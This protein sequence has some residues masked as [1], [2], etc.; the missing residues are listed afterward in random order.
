MASKDPF[1]VAVKPTG[2]RPPARGWAI[3][4]YT[5]AGA[6]LAAALL[7][8]AFAPLES[9]AIAGGLV[10]VDS[11]RKQVQHLEGGIVQKIFVR[12]GEQVQERQELIRLEATKAESTVTTLKARIVAGE[13]QLRLVQDELDTVEA[14]LKRGQATRPR[15]L[16]LQ[17]RKAELQGQIAEHRSELRA[18]EDQIERAVI[19][20]PIAGTVIELK[21]HTA[22]GVIKAG[23]PL[24]S[25]VPRD[26]P[27]VIEAHIDPND[28][29][30]VRPGLAAHIRLTPYNMRYA[31]PL[32]GRVSQV[33][34]DR[35][36][37]PKSG[38]A[39]Y[40]A[41]VQLT[42]KPSEIDPAMKLYPGMPAEVII[43]TGQRTLLGYLAAPISRSF[44][45]A[46]REE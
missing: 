26:D 38:A 34:A 35:F 39:Y 46:L 18:A 16:A 37:D 15:L 7:W 24:M 10:S 6:L 9:A 4:G 21:V 8:G 31:A 42:Q 30:V 19:R 40:L 13:A 22:G 12:E 25:I 17:R 3:V 43:V 14:L 1:T 36:T 44:R 11:N 27:L 28:I 41:R 32:E 20:A 45:R 5:A 2:E 29:D 23:E 33:S